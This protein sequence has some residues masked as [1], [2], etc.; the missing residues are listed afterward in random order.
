MGATV[1]RS[2]W[3]GLQELEGDLRAFMGRRCRDHSELDDVVQ[4]TLL[5]AARFRPSMCD[6]RNLRGWLLRIGS[7][8]LRDRQRR[9]SRMPRSGLAGS[10]SLDEI[11]D[12]REARE[13]PEGRAVRMGARWVDHGEAVALLGWALGYLAPRDR[14]VLDAYYRAGHSTEHIARERDMPRGLVKV[15]LFRARRRLARRLESAGY[16]VASGVAG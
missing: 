10:L 16:R 13:G 12:E 4:E 5:R 6:P 14:D 3:S 7:N 15:R 2:A 9:E 1:A 11:C 8:V